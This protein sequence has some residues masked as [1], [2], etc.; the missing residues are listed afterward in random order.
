MKFLEGFGRRHCNNFV[1]VH[2]KCFYN[3]QVSLGVSKK[4]ILRK[5]NAAA[6]A[7]GMMRSD[8]Q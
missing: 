2:R 4:V 3:I 6:L 8:E 1:T 5:L 7:T